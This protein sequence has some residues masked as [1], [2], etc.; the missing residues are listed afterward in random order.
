M[1]IQEAYQILN[2]TPSSSEEEVKKA[3]KKLA[4]QYHPDKNKEAG[5]EEKFKKIN[6][7]YQTIINK[8]NSKSEFYNQSPF[9]NVDV[10]FSDLF[11]IFENQFNGFGG[12]NQVFINGMPVN[13]PQY[14]PR[15]V[16]EINLSLP[17]A[18]LGCVKS[19]NIKRKIKCDSCDGIGQTYDYTNKCLSCQGKGKKF[20]SD[21]IFEIC[22]ACSGRGFF[23]NDCSKCNS[24][25]NIEQDVE[26]KV[27]IP[28]GI[29]NNQLLK[30]NGASD[31]FFDKKIKR[32]LYIDGFVKIYVQ[33]EP[34]MYVSGQDVIST[35]DLSLLESLKGTVKKVKTIRGEMSLK[36]NKNIKHGDKIGVRGYGVGGYGSHIFVIQVSYPKDTDELIKFLETQNNKEVGD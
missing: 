9:S 11:S 15:T 27:E 20:K 32:G 35:L 21:S 10:N 6:E 22:D 28:A 30:V 26:I 12:F 14:K 7:A 5:A 36:V 34:N 4:L 1:H 2:L 3:F 16:G 25:G 8:T 31:Y 23:K 18:L 17:E 29:E 13:G 24:L 19:L 33:E